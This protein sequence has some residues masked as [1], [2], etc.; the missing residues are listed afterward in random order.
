M[1]YH[2]WH[3]GIIVITG[4]YIL[5][6]L[7]I[8]K[9]LSKEGWQLK[10]LSDFQKQHF[11]NKW[12]MKHVICHWKSCKFNLCHHI[13][14][15]FVVIVV[16][17]LSHVQ[18]FATP[19]TTARQASLSFIISRSLLKLMSSCSFKHPLLLLFLPSLFPPLVMPIRRASPGP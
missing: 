3:V 14:V 12:T 10:P 18:L 5:L 9:G 2:V 8:L 7:E 19:W 4:E 11:Y 1:S 17:L 13:A 15:P 16:H 6:L